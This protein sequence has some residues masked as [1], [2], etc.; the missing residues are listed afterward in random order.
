MNKLTVRGI[1]STR[2]IDKEIVL[3]DGGGL[4]LRV[5]PKGKRT[6]QFRYRFGDARKVI[7]LGSYEHVTL[8]EA[9]TKAHE[10]R[11]L[12]DGGVCPIEHAKQQEDAA[13]AAIEAAKREAE[14]IR[15]FTQVA[16]EWLELD[17][18]RRKDGGAE[19][20]RVF[21]VDV[22][23][24]VGDKP[25]HE[26]KKA[27]VLD[28]VDR[29]TRRGAPVQANHTFSYLRQFLNWCVRRD[30]IE[31]SPLFGLSKEKDAGGIQPS[32]ERFLA[33]DELMQ[34]HDQLPSAGMDKQSELALWI[35]VSTVCRVGELLQ[36]RWDNV[37]FENRT[38]MIPVEN[39]KNAKA[40]TVFLSEFALRQFEVL[41]GVTGWSDWI[42]PAL[43][44]S[45]TGHVCLKSITKQVKDRQRE[46]PPLKGRSKATQSLI[47]QG[48]HWTPHDLR[49][50]GST[51]MGD[52]GVSE[53]IVER[54]MN[55]SRGRLVET[56]Q[57]SQKREK[58]LEAWTLLGEHLDALLE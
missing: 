14:S 2:A 6:W 49:R 23:P 38:W 26:V 44:T 10:A 16:E 4:Q 37:D 56:Y 8:K 1:E 43:K 9:R 20:R 40:H 36:A 18:S 45:V 53:D 21:M 25:I 13:Q 35:L 29:V 33:N 51:I 42:Y 52:A 54:C 34:L 32:R 3:I 50:T 46:T 12:L 47:L 58:M 7:P 11:S 39:A 31:K 19:A 17:V 30:I 27:D 41:R 15:T 48:G 24:H 22:L 5:H 57:R 55:H 28:V